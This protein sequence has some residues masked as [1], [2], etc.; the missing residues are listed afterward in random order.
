[1]ST[2]RL[3][4]LLPL[5]LP[6]VPSCPEPFA[7]HQARMAAITFCEKTRCWRHIVTQDVT[8]NHAKIITLDYATIY[9]F[10]EATLNGVPLIPTQF[11]DA[12]PNELSGDNEG[13]SGRYISQISAGTVGIYPFEAGR[14]RVSCFLKPRHGQLFGTDTDDPLFDAYN[15]IPTFMFEQHALA[16]A[17]GALA[18]IMQTPNEEFTD[19]DRAQNELAKFI[20]ACNSNFANN[21]TGQQRAPKRVKAR[22]I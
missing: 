17:A 13:G 11:T 12:D 20:D 2:T 6:H 10:E 8:E 5:I 14:L 18:N 4:S 1:M 16:L 19:M 9:Q 21:M 3:S 15:M 7:L 22:F